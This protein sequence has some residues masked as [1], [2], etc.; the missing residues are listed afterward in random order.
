VTETHFAWQVNRNVPEVPSPLF[1]QGKLYSVR[2]GGVFTC[3]I[4]DTGENIY[5]DRLKQARGQYASSLIAA[6]GRIYTSSVNGIITVIEA[7]NE[8]N[9]IEQNNIGENIYATP[10]LYKNEI[11]VRTTNHLYAFRE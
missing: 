10:A 1:Y 9:I 3:W 6:D 11:Y 8:L 2:D 4:P 5:R 7:G